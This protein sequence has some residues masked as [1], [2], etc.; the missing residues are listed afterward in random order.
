MCKTIL[1][2][3]EIGAF[4]RAI[5]DLVVTLAGLYFENDL[6]DCIIVLLIICICSSMVLDLLNFD[7]FHI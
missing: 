6:L 4:G 1:L 3:T 5:E 7:I 2:N